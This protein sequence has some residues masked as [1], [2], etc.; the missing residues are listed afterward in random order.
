MATWTTSS[1]RSRRSPLRTDGKTAIVLRADGGRAIGAGH[2]MRCVALARALASD[3]EPILATSADP[4]L[5]GPIARAGITVVPIERAHPHPSDAD[6]IVDLARRV[7]ADTVIV[8]GYHF[9]QGYVT[10]L[11]DAG[12]KTAMIEDE[13]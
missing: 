8:D 13:A 10:R 7:D 3:T 12:L 1:A 6:G 2:L 11:S 4:E 5:I 9:D